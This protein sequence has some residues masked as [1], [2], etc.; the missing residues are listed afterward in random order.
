MPQSAPRNA[1]I[2]NDNPLQS[3]RKPHSTP[4]NLPSP[5]FLNRRFILPCIVHWVTS[6]KLIRKEPARS[7]YLYEIHAPGFGP[8]ER[9]PIGQAENDDDVTRT[10]R[11]LL[12]S[13]E[14][15]LNAVLLMRLPQ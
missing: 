5:R 7:C 2:S 9:S 1:A 8:A 10:M 3:A 14:Q 6:V 11:D 13:L 4:T 12:N 15:P